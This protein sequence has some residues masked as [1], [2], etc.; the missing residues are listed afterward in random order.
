MKKVCPFIIALLISNLLAAQVEQLS[1]EGFS[2]LESMQDTLEQL[3]NTTVNDTIRENRVNAAEDFA[4]NLKSALETPNSFKFPFNKLKSASIQS[5]ADSSFRIFTLQL[6]VNDDDYRYWGIIQ[7]NSA[8]LQNI[9][10]NSNAV[11]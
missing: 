1:S 7:R 5:P 3:A 11:G 10:I 4:N 2:L 6:F 9:A 8:D